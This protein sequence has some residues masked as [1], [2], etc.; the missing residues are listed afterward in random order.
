[1][2]GYATNLRSLTQGRASS[3]MEF[4]EYQETPRNV[5]EA[6]VKERTGKE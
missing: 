5:T 6:I 1:M 3:S 2:F 4:G